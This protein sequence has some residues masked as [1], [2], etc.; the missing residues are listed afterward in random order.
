M[1]EVHIGEALGLLSALQWV[2]KLSLRPI[3]F[4]LDLK[5]VVDNFAFNKHDAT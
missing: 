3:D 1:C 4:E 2:D 5:K